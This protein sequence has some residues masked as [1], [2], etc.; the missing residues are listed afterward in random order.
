MTK[1]A[2][3]AHILETFGSLRR[4]PET[5]A[6]TRGACASCSARRTTQRAN[7]NAR[8]RNSAMRDLGMVR[9]SQGWE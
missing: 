9:T 7:R 5:V 2:W 6:H 4:T 1:Q 8:E 3:L